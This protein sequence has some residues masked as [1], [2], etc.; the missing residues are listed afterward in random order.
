MINIKK[1][2][3]RLMGRT[4]FQIRV[5][6]IGIEKEKIILKGYIISRKTIINPS[7]IVFSLNENA[8]KS[9]FYVRE[10]LERAYSNFSTKIGFDL[11]VNE[12]K[13]QSTQEKIIV[14]YKRRMFFLNIPQY[15]LEKI[16]LEKHT[17]MFG[18]NSDV[19]QKRKTKL[20]NK[21]Y[22]N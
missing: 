8:I 6:E 9:H 10:D 14:K 19:R 17:W 3:T 2:Y 12:K 16:Y 21:M 15:F 4:N 22:P 13:H 1:I 7:K 18:Y 11:C 20:S 5:E